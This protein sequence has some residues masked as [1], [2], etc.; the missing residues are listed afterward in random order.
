MPQPVL[1]EDLVVDRK[2]RTARIAEYRVDTLIQQSAD[3]H[4]RAGHSFFGHTC[5]PRSAFTRR[6]RFDGR[7]ST[8]IHAPPAPVAA[9]RTS[10]ESA[11]PS[12]YVSASPQPKTHIRE[13]FPLPTFRKI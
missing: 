13:H 3:H 11:Q 4:L 6:W 8:R 12:D 10:V 9:E 2:D 1:L 5:A 7:S